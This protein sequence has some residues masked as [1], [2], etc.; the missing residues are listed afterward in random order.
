MRS[1]RNFGAFTAKQMWE[2]AIILPSKTSPRASTC[3]RRAREAKPG[4]STANNSGGRSR[5]RRHRDQCSKLLPSVERSVSRLEAERR[6]SVKCVEFDDTYLCNFV[7]SFNE[8]N[9]AEVWSRDVSNV[10]MRHVLSSRNTD[11]LGHSV[12]GSVLQHGISEEL[13]RP[14]QL[15]CMI[16]GGFL[17]RAR[18]ESK[19][20]AKDVCRSHL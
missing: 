1:R 19:T 14:Y 4:F 8:G 9:P 5:E 7:G 11:K 10:M 3:A 6:D 2:Q 12:D 18:L 17:R 15:R 13:S 16:L 20:S